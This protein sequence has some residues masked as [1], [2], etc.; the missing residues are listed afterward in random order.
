MSWAYALLL[1]AAAIAV[2][3]VYHAMK[4]AAANRGSD[5]D[6]QLVKNL[7]AQ[8]G[9]AFR[10]YDIDFF[11]GMPTAAA[12]QALEASLLADGCSV[13]FREATT[14]GASGYTLRARKVMRVS[15]PEMQDHSKRYRELAQHYGGSYDGWATE[16]ITQP[17]Q[18]TVRLRPRGIPRRF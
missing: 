16:G 13:D 2:F 14:E 18:D 9:T 7:R 8:G 4:R 6:E 3:R 5:W 11:F 1:A 17:A 15:V 10:D 12:C